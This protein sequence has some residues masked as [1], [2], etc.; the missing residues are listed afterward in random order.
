MAL[1]DSVGVRE[2]ACVLLQHTRGLMSA[3]FD[4]HG[5]LG[6]VHFKLEGLDCIQEAEDE[7]VCC[8]QVGLASDNAM[9]R[10]VI[11]I[12]RK[13]FLDSVPAESANK[14]MQKSAR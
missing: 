11:G 10:E 4:Q 7:L 8:S 14:G 6:L 9:H 1:K 3:Q 12:P 13:K 2:P 5:A